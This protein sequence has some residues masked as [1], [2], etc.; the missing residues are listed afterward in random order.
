MENVFLAGGLTTG[1]ILYG[2]RFLRQRDEYSCGPI[3]V[4]NAL[5]WAGLSLTYKQNFKEIKELCKTTK[6]WG[7]TPS[8]ITNV[9][10][11]YIEY[12]CFEVKEL[13]TLKDIEKH[14]KHGGALILE[15]WF[16]DDLEFDGHYVFIL[17]KDEDSF[18]IANG[19]IGDLALSTCSRE[20]L[21]NMLR[22]KKYRCTGSPSA[23]LITTR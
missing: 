21:K 17:E 12:I 13:I 6:S 15:Y 2:V 16:K 14:I 11:Q 19:M 10:S 9:L 7:T 22:C 23:W 18:I 8:N 5:K 3:A 1:G 20:E 4:L